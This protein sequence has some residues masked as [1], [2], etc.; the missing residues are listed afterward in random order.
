MRDDEAIAAKVVDVYEQAVRAP[1]RTVVNLADDVGSPAALAARLAGRP[2][3]S[4]DLPED[5]YR[6]FRALASRP[7]LRR[8][9]FAI[10][11]GIYV[12]GHVVKHRRLPERIV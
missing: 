12:L 11:H 5:A 3:N 1:D 7:M 10:L 4:L 2:L 6:A 9:L 8:P